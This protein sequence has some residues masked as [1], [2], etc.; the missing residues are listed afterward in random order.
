[1]STISSRTSLIARGIYNH[2]PPNPRT[3]MQNN[4]TLLVCWW[5]TAASLVIIG[6]RIVGRYCRTNRFFTEDKV[7]MVAVVPLIA[8]MTLVHLVLIWGTN[9]AK[10]D[11]LS[12]IDIRDREI[13]SRLVLVARIF[14]AV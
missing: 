14:Y 11:G 10:T 1:M 5:C 4:P 7:M 6:V 9:N 13:G 12:E 2:V 8:R 3:A